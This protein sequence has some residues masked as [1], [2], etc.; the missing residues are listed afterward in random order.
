M[1]TIILKLFF[2][3]TLNKFQDNSFLDFNN[4]IKAKE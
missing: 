3:K 1:I 2:L 4:V